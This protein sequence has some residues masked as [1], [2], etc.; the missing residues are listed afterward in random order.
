MTGLALGDLQSISREMREASEARN[1]NFS[2]A[3][4]LKG[5]QRTL[6]L[7]LMFPLCSRLKIFSACPTDWPAVGRFGGARVTWA[8]A[9]TIPTTPRRPSEQSAK[10]RPQSP[11]SDN[12]ARANAGSGRI[13]TISNAG[14]Q[15]LRSRPAYHPLG[16]R[17][18]ERLDQAIIPLP[19]MRPQRRDADNPQ[20]GRYAEWAGAVSG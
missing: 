14:T 1:I 19:K 8:A 10:P 3:Q 15:P 18:F 4:N 17:R 13:A 5:R 7:C 2:H 11:Q 12:S 6:P 9:V 20:L 16:R